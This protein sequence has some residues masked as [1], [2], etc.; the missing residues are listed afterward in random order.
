MTLEQMVLQIE[1][2]AKTKNI[3]C[4]C[5]YDVSTCELKVMLEKCGHSTYI[6]FPANYLLNLN[7]ITNS[8]LSKIEEG[9][10][11]LNNSFM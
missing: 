3:L 10:E 4:F 1:Q 2:I 5:D 11:L 8:I 6:K 7:S 9:C